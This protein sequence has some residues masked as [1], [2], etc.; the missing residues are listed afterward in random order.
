MTQSS[1]YYWPKEVIQ[2]SS[3]FLW[4]IVSLVSFII[5]TF[6]VINWLFQFSAL[7]KAIKLYF[8]INLPSWSNNC[9]YICRWL[10]VFIPKRCSNIC[11]E[12]RGSACAEVCCAQDQLRSHVK[13]DTWALPAGTFLPPRT[14][15]FP[16]LQGV[17]LT[18]YVGSLVWLL[19]LLD[20]R[21][22]I[23]GLGLCSLQ[24]WP[25]W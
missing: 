1:T 25:L 6:K 16:F 2:P 12:F 13:W 4:F 18:M 5:M 20:K 8:K 10:W 11:W 15:I 24:L 23:S 9:L 17:F 14:L 19:D 22:W 7:L 21:D 3:T